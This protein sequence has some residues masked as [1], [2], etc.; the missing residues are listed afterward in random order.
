[1]RMLGLRVVIALCA[2]SAA[3]CAGTAYS[4]CPNY[5]FGQIE[6]ED[7]EACAQ[8]DNAS[9]LAADI[10]DASGT[11]PTFRSDAKSIRI[12]WL[13]VDHFESLGRDLGGLTTVEGVYMG[14]SGYA[15]VHEMM[16]VHYRAPNDWNHGGWREGGQF[17]LAGIFDYLLFGDAPAFNDPV[18]MPA[19]EREALAKAGYG[20]QTT[21]VSPN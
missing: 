16:H 6:A 15:L 21:T 9:L 5:V 14:R 8:A 18:T 12:I 20:D 13:R 19:A 3:G 2:L 4:V 17:A 7:P 11:W 1:M 10:I